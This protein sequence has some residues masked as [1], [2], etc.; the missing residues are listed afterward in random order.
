MNRF[1]GSTTASILAILPKDAKYSEHCR[2][3]FSVSAG[4]LRVFRLSLLTLTSNGP[5][6]H[7]ASQTL[8]PPSNLDAIARQITLRSFVQIQPRNQ[9]LETQALGL[10]VWR[11]M[12]LDSGKRSFVYAPWCASDRKFYI[13][14]LEH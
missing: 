12:S 9:F 11:L 1:F 5:D 10:F 14:T 3:F 2:R 8:Y 4:I 13:G 6:A 7:H